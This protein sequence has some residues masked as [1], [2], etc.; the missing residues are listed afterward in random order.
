MNELLYIINVHS[1]SIACFKWFRCGVSLAS[2]HVNGL[3]LM[4]VD[5]RACGMMLSA[6]T[7]ISADFLKYNSGIVVVGMVASS[8]LLFGRMCYFHGRDVDCG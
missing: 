4:N 3:Q 8:Y 7:T 2:T 6:S 5:T 1:A